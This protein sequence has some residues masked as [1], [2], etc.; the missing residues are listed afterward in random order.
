MPTIL[1][2]KNM[3]FSMHVAAWHYKIP[4]RNILLSIDIQTTLTDKGS[5]KKQKQKRLLIQSI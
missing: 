5:H 1:F 2:L 4:C 3:N